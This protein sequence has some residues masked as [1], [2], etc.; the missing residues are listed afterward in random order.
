MYMGSCQN[1]GPFLGTLNLRCR[2]IL[3]TQK[4][5]IILA[6]T[7]MVGYRIVGSGFRVLGAGFRICCSRVQ[8]LPESL[9]GN[10]E[11]WHLFLGLFVSV[12]EWLWSFAIVGFV[13]FWFC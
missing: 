10:T 7:H 13:I 12:S 8:L 3:R 2:I 6:T 1:Y 4:G 5:T 9:Q 11:H